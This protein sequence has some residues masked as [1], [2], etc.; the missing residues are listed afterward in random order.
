MKNLSQKANFWISFIL[1]FGGCAL[2]MAAM[3][4]GS[5]W[6]LAIGTVL[7]VAGIIFLRQ[8]MSV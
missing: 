4:Q 7:L 1:L 2:S 6:L 5:L 8:A 3:F